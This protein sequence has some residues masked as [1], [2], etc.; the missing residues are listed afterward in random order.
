VERK[1]AAE[2][3][4]L[5]SIPIILASFLYEVVGIKGHS[6]LAA[7]PTIVAFIAA[8]VSG[9]FAIKFMLRVIQNV[10]LHWFSLYLVVLAIVCLFLF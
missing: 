5:M 3:S 1:E 10:K 6:V 7:G 8:L 4:F 2:Y 9:V